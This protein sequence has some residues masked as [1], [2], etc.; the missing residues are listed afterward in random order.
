MLL[1]GLIVDWTPEG[2]ISELKNISIEFCKTEK[3]RKQ[4]EKTPP[5]PP[6]QQNIQGL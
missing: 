1:M 2:R 4:T 5:P 3:Q 6:P